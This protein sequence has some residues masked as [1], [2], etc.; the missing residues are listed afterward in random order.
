MTHYDL[1]S[2]A[3][4]LGHAKTHEQQRAVIDSYPELKDFSIPRVLDFIRAGKV[5]GTPA[6][7]KPV[8]PDVPDLTLV[9]R[10][11]EWDKPAD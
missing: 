6:P 3:H 2:L 11:I 10:R 4:R 9:K 1:I 7:T 5:D 8:R